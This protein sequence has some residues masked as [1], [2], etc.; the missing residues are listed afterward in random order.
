MCYSVERVFIAFYLASHERLS[1]VISFYCF[2]TRFYFL[3]VHGKMFI[4]KIINT[5][6]VPR[7]DKNKSEERTNVVWCCEKKKFVY[8]FIIVP[9]L[10]GIVHGETKIIVLKT[11]LKR[12][13]FF[14]VTIKYYFA[15]LR[16]RPVWK[17]RIAS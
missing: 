5:Y 1:N 13:F 4:F 3:R 9:S 6:V 7:T 2:Y 16:I 17:S 10:I 11:H 14:C 12:Y 15:S 8:L